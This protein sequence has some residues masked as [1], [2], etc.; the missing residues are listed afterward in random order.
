MG[1]M[2]MVGVP[3]DMTTTMIG[4]FA[5]GLVVDDTVHFI[6]NF[7][8]YYTLTGN[9]YQA[10]KETMIGA[11]RALVITSFIAALS[12]DLVVVPAFLTVVTKKSNVKRETVA[13]KVSMATTLQEVPV[14]ASKGKQV[15][16]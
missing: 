8:K 10:V 6:Y 2:G 16:T 13:R 15:S 3:L 9:T 1:I 14:K 11:G 7:Q 5:M 4:C 12:A